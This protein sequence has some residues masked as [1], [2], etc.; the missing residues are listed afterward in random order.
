MSANLAPDVVIT[1]RNASPLPSAGMTDNLGLASQEGQG[2][3]SSAIF[4]GGRRASSVG[5]YLAINRNQ[6]SALQAEDV[7][8]RSTT[9]V[10]GDGHN[11]LDTAVVE[12]EE[13]APETPFEEGV[14]MPYDSLGTSGRHIH[15]STHSPAM[16]PS[17]LAPLES[18]F[19]RSTATSIME[20]NPVPSARTSMTEITRMQME[21][22][23]DDPITPG[24]IASLRGAT[25]IAI[26]ATAQLMDLIYLTAV[27]IALP[28]MQKELN[29]ASGN[30]QWLVSAYTLAFGGF[31]LLAGVVADRF[32][33]KITFC[34][35]M[36]WL[37][38]WSLAVSFAQ[39]E[40]SAII[41]RALQGLGAA[42]T[43]PS[44]IGVIC[45]YFAGKEQHRA[46]SCYGAAGAVGFVAG[47]I[48][49]GL[50]T[51]SLGWVQNPVMP[52]WLWKQPSFA[53]I[54]FTAFFMQACWLLQRFSTKKIIVTALG[55][56]ILA[57]IPSA[58]MKPYQSFWAST[59]LTMMIAVTGVSWAYN[60]LAIT[61]VAS[62]PAGIKSTS[63]G[64]INTAFQIGTAVGLSL[65]G[66]VSGSVSGHNK[67]TE[68]DWATMRAYSAALWMSTGLVGLAF[69]IALFGI[70]G[71]HKVGGQ[72]PVH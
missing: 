71:G 28:Q 17:T 57:N 63:G 24:K 11:G 55:V 36:A 8:K 67:E 53:A 60:V 9:P 15:F 27:N 72:M 19:P 66:V 20:L 4:A 68:D 50:L 58:I 34:V 62:V 22:S 29:I 12:E 2:A 21:D 37:T 64:L 30:L 45:T 65:C 23:A 49:G 40:I 25:I 61:L 51:A 32:G 7:M 46:M 47:L 26:T 5:A 1:Q 18:P 31:L 54:W 16:T 69:L 10:A 56:C 3:T 59:F 44:A 14:D 38:I 48:L 13:G 33:K 43:V 41:F 52:L 70:K 6:I 35:G 39:N 42:A